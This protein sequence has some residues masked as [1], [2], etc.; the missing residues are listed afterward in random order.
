MTY[1]EAG[2]IYTHTPLES[3][4]FDIDACS[5]ACSYYWKSKTKR[6]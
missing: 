2:S 1:D 4:S 5:K 3:V 6:P